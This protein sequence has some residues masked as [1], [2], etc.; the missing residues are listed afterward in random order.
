[1][2]EPENQIIQ[3][4]YNKKKQ[5]WKELLREDVQQNKFMIKRISKNIYSKLKDL[6]EKEDKFIRNNKENIVD[7]NIKI[8]IQGLE[9]DENKEFILDKKFNILLLKKENVNK[10]NIIVKKIN[11]KEL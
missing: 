9:E 8:N 10:N 7:N 11:R 1:M 4:D 3:E 5:E 6:K 2:K